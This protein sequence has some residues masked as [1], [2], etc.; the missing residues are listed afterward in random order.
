MAFAN[1]TIDYIIEYSYRAFENRPPK[2]V[3]AKMNTMI[4]AHKTNNGYLF[5]TTK[6]DLLDMISSA[7]AASKYAIQLK[8]WMLEQEKLELDI[9]LENAYKDA[10]NAKIKKEEMDRSAMIWHQTIARRAYI[11]TIS[12]RYVLSSNGVLCIQLI[13]CLRCCG[14]YD[15]YIMRLIA[16]FA[17]FHNSI[18]S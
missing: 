1:A 18:E 13:L 5:L 17:G 11:P 12:S 7:A 3:V 9:A 16:Y 6:D 10:L 8:K 15:V 4:K 2:K 14:I